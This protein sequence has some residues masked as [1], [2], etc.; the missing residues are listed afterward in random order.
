MSIPS[1]SKSIN[2]H[3]IMHRLPQ[4]SNQILQ[5]FLNINKHQISIYDDYSQVRCCATDIMSQL[6]N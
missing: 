5:H 2:S 3:E 4:I 1:I 6:H